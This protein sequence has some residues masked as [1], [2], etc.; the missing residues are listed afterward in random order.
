MQILESD[1]DDNSMRMVLS[2]PEM[3]PIVQSAL[4]RI[5]KNM[6]ETAG[7]TGCR[8]ITYATR[9]THCKYP[10]IKV[11]GKSIYCHI[12]LAIEWCWNNDIALP[13]PFNWSVSHDCGNRLCGIHVSV[14]HHSKNQAREYCPC[15]LQCKICET[16]ITACSC[17]PLCAKPIKIGLCS[18]CR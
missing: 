6:K 3:R 8:E 2:K 17:D 7:P 16:V 18:K 11:A 10:T 9:A 4:A 13:W 14:Q 5:R 1:R 12:I 15:P